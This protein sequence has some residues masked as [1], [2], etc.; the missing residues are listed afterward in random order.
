V[1]VALLDH[2]LQPNAET[3]SRVHIPG[4]T[5]RV[6]EVS[7]H[8]HY[9]SYRDAGRPRQL[10]LGHAFLHALARELGA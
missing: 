7:F 10:L 9:R 2:I 4:E 1:Q 5:R 3:S 6:D 8:P